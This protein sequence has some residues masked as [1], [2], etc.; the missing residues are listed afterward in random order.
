MKEGA[1][2]TVGIVRS[3]SRGCSRLDENGKKGDG[4]EGSG[5]GEKGGRE[6]DSGGQ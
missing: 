1:V 5:R 2:V 6:R 3:K 4:K